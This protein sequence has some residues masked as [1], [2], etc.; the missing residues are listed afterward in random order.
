MGAPPVVK[1]VYQIYPKFF[2]RR[3]GA[4]DGEELLGNYPELAAAGI[5]DADKSNFGFFMMETSFLS[6]L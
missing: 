2:Y 4:G 3:F 1:V 5:V 6:C